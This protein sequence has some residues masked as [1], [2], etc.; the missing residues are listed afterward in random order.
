MDKQR[1]HIYQLSRLVFAQATDWNRV[2]A[3]IEAGRN[4]M[5]WSYKP[6]RLGAFNLLKAKDTPQIQEI[7]SNVAALAEKAGGGR[8][9]TAN[10]KALRVFESRF[11]PS[12]ST[13]QENY[14]ESIS[15]GVEFAGVELI[16]GPHFSVLDTEARP[17]FVYLHPSKWKEDQTEAFCELLT[18]VLEQRF[19]VPASALW[20][21]DLRNGERVDWPKSKSRVRKKCEQATRLLA[22]LRSANFE[23][24]GE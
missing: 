16:G 1:F 15:S 2:L 18:I 6:V 3:E 24:E 5:F 23:Q 17:R 19:E 21:L 22:R 11:V 8:C 14:M 13:P 12:I 7:Y 10:V 20:F 9:Q 4:Q